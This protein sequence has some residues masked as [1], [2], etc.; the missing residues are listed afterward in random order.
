MPMFHRFRGGIHPPDKKSSTRHKPVEA[1]PPPERVVLPVSMHVGAPCEPVVRLDQ[2]V[3]M[4]QL[5]ADSKEALSAP[6]HS[7]VSGKVLAIDLHPH[8]NGTRVLS[9]FIQ[10]DG[11]DTPHESVHPHGSVEALPPEQL[12]SIIRG[13]G[14]V[15]M[16]G[17]AIPTHYKIA[18]AQGRC[19]TVIINAAECEPYIT[20]DHR[21][22]LQAPEEILGG[23]RVLMKLLEP[24]RAVIAVQ[25]N[26][27]DALDTLRRTLPG[28][29][30]IELTALSTRYPQGSERQ[31]IKSVTGREV[32]PGKPSSSV[33]C[34]VFNAKTAAALHRAVTIGTPLTSRIVTVSGSAVANA[35]NLSVRFGTPL[36]DIFN[37]TGGF[38]EPPAKVL[39]GGPMMGAAQHDLSA[40]LVK[41][42]GAL[43]AF[44][45]VDIPPAG[46]EICIRCGRCVRV[47]P[48]RLLPIYL[49]MNE[50][51]NRLSELE[52]L[53]IEDCSECGSC[54]YICPG[55]L[56]LVHSIR[57][58]K[59]KLL[60][61]RKETGGV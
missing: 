45:T 38:R 49:Y 3:F 37:A 42:C 43:L 32:P 34:A 30:K 39:T 28:K 60:D 4:G 48:M 24:R 19:D 59:Q 16:G 44:S 7:P 53:H 10:N 27:R 26:K 35:K 11:Q 20:S 55:R 5:V 56:Y 12:L 41:G 47:C 22:M 36:S 18:E 1:L 15:G 29:S 23:L 9:I 21:L 17:S 61:E 2:E 25:K 58:G 14:I 8:L 6:I 54:S 40:P 57:T 50:R 13:A 33:K 46:D 31:L 51:K 52:R